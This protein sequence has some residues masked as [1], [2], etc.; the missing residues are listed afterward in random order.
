MISEFAIHKTKKQAPRVHS[1]LIFFIYE[2]QHLII[3]L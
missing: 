2:R 3:G 1:G